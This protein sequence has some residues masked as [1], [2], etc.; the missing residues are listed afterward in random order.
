M[1]MCIRLMEW[2][3]KSWKGLLLKLT[4]G[5]NVSSST[6]SFFLFWATALL[7]A[8]EN[9]GFRKCKVETNINHVFHGHET[10]DK[11]YLQGLLCLFFFGFLLS[12]EP[13]FKLTDNR[14]HNNVEWI[15]E[16]GGKH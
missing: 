8:W 7:C 3:K 13:P 16:I 9:Q 2:T 6:S 5:S 1:H 15:D 11:N 10:A 12:L 14:K 4:L